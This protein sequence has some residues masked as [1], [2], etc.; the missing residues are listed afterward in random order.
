MESK[1]LPKLQELGSD[2]DY[3]TQAEIQDLIAYAADRGIRVV[4]EFD[5]PGHSTA[6]FVGY[7]EIASGP[8]PTRSTAT[9]GSWIRP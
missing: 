9:G 2:G 8:G 5:M 1:K 7:P 6:W 4:P 3:Y